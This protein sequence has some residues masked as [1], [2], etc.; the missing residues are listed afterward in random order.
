MNNSVHFNASHLETLISGWDEEQ[1]VDFKNKVYNVDSDETK[2]KFARHMIAFANVARRIG[3][4]CWMVF[5]VDD[6]TRERKSVFDQYPRPKKPRF[7]DAPNAILSKK[8]KDGVQQAYLDI[9]TQ[10]INP[11]PDFQLE[12]GELNGVFLSYLEI[13]PSY[14]SIPF[15]L[16][17]VPDKNSTYTVGTVF[18]RYGSQSLPVEP[19]EVQYIATKSQAAYL[20]A[21]DW[22][23]LV[24][25]HKAGE[26]SDAHSLVPSFQHKAMDGADALALVLQLLDENRRRVVITAEAGHG[27]TVLLQ[28]IAFALAERHPERLENK[29]FAKPREPEQM[30]RIADVRKLETVPKLPVP[31][32]M[33]LRMYFS[34]TTEFERRLLSHVREISPQVKI[35]SLDSL[36]RIPGSHWVILLDGVDELKNAERAGA[37][38]QN[39]VESLPQNVQVILTARPYA[40]FE[41]K[42][43]E[44][45]AL[46]QLSD[47]ETMQLLRDHLQS[48][49]REPTERVVIEEQVLGKLDHDHEL[50]KL[51]RCPRAM[52]GFL[53]GVL[54]EYTSVKPQIDIDQVQVAA[55]AP[56]EIKEGQGPLQFLSVEPNL[57]QD[58]E[59]DNVENQ[60]TEPTEE[61][62]FVFSV[63]SL[64]ISVQQIVEHMKNEEIKRHKGLGNTTAERTAVKAQN[65]LRQVAW[66]TDWDSEY[67]NWFSC[68]RKRWLTEKSLV[69]NQN[70]GFIR[71]QDFETFY[72]YC[73]LL[74]HF[75]AA[76]HAFKRNEK[77]LADQFEKVGKSSPGGMKI[78]DL[79]ND[80]RTENGKDK[81]QIS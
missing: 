59:W 55:R 39:W 23:N 38:L 7:W 44:S 71:T 60:D 10:W 1:R 3:E 75:E 16:K 28:R 53:V 50:L 80:L 40:T 47:D 46:A 51:L 2:L 61:N 12:Y 33:D 72:F 62:P 64:A 68:Q 18:L 6:K 76:A 81:I 36:W 11:K 8:Q 65:A 77:R 19:S 56:I 35:E 73:L 21:T 29:Y 25:Y 5:G 57:A 66:N 31:V 49:L 67:F 17:C 27:K 69:W 9:A 20:T 58:T 41:W 52:I 45:I 70:I 22:A 54:G 43:T 79:L 37:Q 24:N 32:F 74:K 48:Q 42:G 13:K 26:F 30:E 4:P 34:N 63:P 14:T 15:S 78:L